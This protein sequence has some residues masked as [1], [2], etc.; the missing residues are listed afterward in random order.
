MKRIRIKCAALLTPLIFDTAFAQ[1]A[2]PRG[3]TPLTGEITLRYTPR[4]ESRCSMKSYEKLPGSFF[5]SR[6][7]ETSATGVSEESPGVSK[8]WMDHHAGANFVRMT[9]GLNGDGSGMGTDDPTLM[10]DLPVTAADKDAFSKMMQDKSGVFRK[11][12]ESVIGVP[13][14]QGFAIRR[15]MCELTANA[16]GEGRTGQYSVMGV[17]EIRGRESVV[18]GGDETETCV[19]P[20][21]RFTMQLKGWYAV[22]RQ[23]GLPAGHSLAANVNVAGVIVTGTEDNECVINGIALRAPQAQPT[24]APAVKSA[25]QRLTELKLL[26]DK[27]LITQEQ[28]E[29]KRAEIVKAL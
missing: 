14:R 3:I 12:M 8:L 10:S 1:Q 4:F 6:K 18:I 15:D 7:T 2:P 22:D 25:E 23:S 28:Y 11:A 29:L 16:K 9:F 5:G 17:A 19:L 13:L 26:L 20:N 21:G 24:V 27:G